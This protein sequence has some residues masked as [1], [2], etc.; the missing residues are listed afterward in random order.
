MYRVLVTD[1]VD[2]ELISE[3]TSRR[4]DVTCRPGITRDELIR[5]IPEYDVL[6]VRSRTKVTREVIDAGRRLKVIARAGVGLDN[7]AVEYAKSRGIEVINA[8]E[9]PTESVAELTIGLMIAAARMIPLYDRLV[10]E[11]QWP[12]G[13]F[14]GIELYGKTLGIVGLG[15]IGSRVAEIARA[16]G[17]KVIAYDIAD[18]REKAQK[19]GVELVSSLDELL[20]RCDVISLHVPLTKET[21]HMISW[22]EFELMK[23][24]VILIN[25]SRGEVVDTRALLE[26]LKRGKAAAAALD[27]LENEPPREEWEL[28]LVRHPRVIVTPHIGAET[29]EAR[30][31]IAQ[32]IAH[33]IYKLLCKQSN[34]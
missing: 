15:R 23:D 13:R 12:K 6:V 30:R 27:V 11:G 2:E 28:E 17:M 9:G 25:T 7:I 5:I 16:L 20:P 21:Y 33:K 31:R 26:A 32:I 4:F 3:L 24:G 18:V 8:P 10:K 1:E 34:A 22:R 14:I 19:L 29:F